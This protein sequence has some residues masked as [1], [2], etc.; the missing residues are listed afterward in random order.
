M[1]GLIKKISKLDRILMCWWIF[2]GLTHMVL[3][4]YFVFSPEF[5]KDKTHFYLAEV[6]KFLFL[7]FYWFNS[8]SKPLILHYWFEFDQTM[9]R[10][11]VQQRWFKIC[12][13][14]FWSCFCRRNYS[15]IGGS[16]LPSYT[17]R[18]MFLYYYL[19]YH[20]P[21]CVFVCV[22]LNTNMAILAGTP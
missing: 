4:G 13:T 16:C 2:T 14:R 5:Y 11:R 21:V 19:S 8:F 17:V 15:S 20:L 10:E 9:H 22:C 3:E 1:L 6:C 18:I 12:R 7:S